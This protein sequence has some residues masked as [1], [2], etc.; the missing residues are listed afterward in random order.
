MSFATQTEDGWTIGYIPP[1]CTVPTYRHI[2]TPTITI[3]HNS[4]SRDCVCAYNGT[5]TLFV[6]MH[7]EE[8]RC[9][10]SITHLADMDSCVFALGQSGVL[11][12]VK[13]GELVEMATPSLLKAICSAQGVII[14]ITTADD[15]YECWHSAGL[16]FQRRY[17]GSTFE[18][19]DVC[20]VASKTLLGCATYA[21]WDRHNLYWNNSCGEIVHEQVGDSIKSCVIDNCKVVVLMSSGSVVMID[22]DSRKEVRCTDIAVGLT[23]IT[24]HGSLAGHYITDEGRVRDLHKGVSHYI[25]ISATLGNCPNLPCCTMTKSANKTA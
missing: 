5:D 21:M 23:M 25:G 9:P 22:I 13:D 24:T 20:D 15:M 17:S 4:T 3:L 16:V 1:N 8:V 6:G 7:D 11:Y 18:L 19:D 2:N 12:C 14:C 10:E